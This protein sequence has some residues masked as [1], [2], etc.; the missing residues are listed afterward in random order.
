IARWTPAFRATRCLPDGISQRRPGRRARRSRSQYTISFVAT[1]ASRCLDEAD[2]L[3]FASGELGA[4]RRREALRH[5]DECE[6]CRS[7]AAELARDVVSPPP[8]GAGGS[9]DVTDAPEAHTHVGGRYRLIKVLGRGAMG[10]VYRAH[11][12]T[13]G[14]DVAL[15]LLRAAEDSGEP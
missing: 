4:E 7:L 10:T 11:D 13:L 12:E 2:I 15:K 8:S 3:A 6:S 1:S 9:A 14:T 5:V